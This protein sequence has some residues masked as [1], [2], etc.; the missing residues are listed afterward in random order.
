MLVPLKRSTIYANMAAGKFPKPI[1]LGSPHA[2]AWLASEI[3]EW[4]QTQIRVARPE[5]SQ[6]NGLQAS[7]ETRPVTPRRFGKRT[8]K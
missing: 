7:S 2:V 1:P 3:D 4:I 6:N 5:E 8:R